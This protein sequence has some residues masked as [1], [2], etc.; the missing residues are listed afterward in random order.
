[1][2]GD[3]SFRMLADAVLAAHFAF[4]VF[5]V[6]GLALI[7]VGGVRGWPWVR[8]P[9]F[10]LAH[11]GAIAIVVAQAWLGAVCPLTTLEM[12]LRRRAGDA[13][14]T[15]SF[16]AH[17]LEQLLY[18]E[19]PAWVFAVGYSAFALLVI[20]TWWRFPPRPLRRRRPENCMWN[21]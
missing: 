19:A 2:T 1:M 18:Y 3:A 13:S 15:G 6:L 21:R 16:I 9:I 11:L 5:V 10:R 14:Y 20:G 8:N 4:V 7:V 12:A 17:W